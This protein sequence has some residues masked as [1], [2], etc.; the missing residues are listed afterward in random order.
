MRNILGM[1]LISLPFIGVFYVVAK[2]DGI[3]EALI[4]F[5][6]VSAII[7]CILAGGLLLSA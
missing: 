6:V 3:Q 1:I 2:T 5:G 7:S 4:I